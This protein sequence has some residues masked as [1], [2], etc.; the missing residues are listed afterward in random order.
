[1][2]YINVTINGKIDSKELWEDVKCYDIN[3]TDLGEV[4]FVYGEVSMFDSLIIISICRKYGDIIHE[5]TSI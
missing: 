2:V 3:V 4:T 1:M 5:V